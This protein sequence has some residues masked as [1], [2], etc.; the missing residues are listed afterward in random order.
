MLCAF[1]LAKRRHRPISERV[2]VCLRETI[3]RGVFLI[4]GPIIGAIIG[5]VIGEERGGRVLN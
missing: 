1:L 3:L 4:I 5:P 2:S